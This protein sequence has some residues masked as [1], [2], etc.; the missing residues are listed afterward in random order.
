LRTPTRSFLCYLP[1]GVIYAA[2]T[3]L[4]SDDRLGGA[5][6][7]APAGLPHGVS[8]SSCFSSALAGVAPVPWRSV[9]P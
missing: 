4:G 9:T 7:A 5:D 1:G 2:P 6:Y 3:G 8:R